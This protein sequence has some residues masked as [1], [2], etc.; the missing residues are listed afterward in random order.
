[1]TGH[2]L[3]LWTDRACAGGEMI[4]EVDLE[5]DVIEGQ[6]ELSIDYSGGFNLRVVESARWFPAAEIGRVLRVD[7]ASGLTSEWRINFIGDAGGIE[8]SKWIRCEPGALD[9]ARRCGFL[10]YR[11][12]GGLTRMAHG[13][14]QLA[15]H[16][17]IDTFL[18]PSLEHYGVTW[19]E[20]GVI[21]STKRID[22]TFE[23]WTPWQLMVALSDA[24]GLE[25][26]ERRIGDTG[27]ALDLV[28]QI[29]GNAEPV[30]LSTDK[31]LLR[32]VRTF[33]GGELATAVV[34]KGAAYGGDGERWGIEHA[35]WRVADKSGNTLTLEAHNGGPGP[36]A[37]RDQLVGRFVQR[38]DGTLTQVV[39]SDTNQ[40]VRVEDASG[41]NVGDDVVFVE[42]SAGSLMYELRNPTSAHGL[43]VATYTDNELRGERNHII[44][45]LFERWDPSSTDFQWCKVVGLGGDQYRYQLSGLRPGT[46][47]NVGDIV[48]YGIATPP[49]YSGARKV[50]AGGT[51]DGAGEVEITLNGGISV[52]SL[53]ASVIVVTGHTLPS[54]W[55]G[56]TTVFPRPRSG[57]SVPAVVD[58][59]HTFTDSDG[60]TG[61]L[62]LRGLPP[63]MPIYFGDGINGLSFYPPSRQTRGVAMSQAVVGPDGKV[64]LITSQ[65][66]EAPDGAPVTLVRPEIFAPGG[67]QM[68]YQWSSSPMVYPVRINHYPGMPTVWFT[69]AFSAYLLSDRVGSTLNIAEGDFRIEVWKGGPK[70]LYDKPLAAVWNPD[71]VSLGLGEV[72]DITLTASLDLTESMDLEF[73]VYPLRAN[74]TDYASILRYAA[75]TVKPEYN[76]GEIPFEGSLGTDI[77]QEANR[78]LVENAK[79]ARV[80]ECSVLDVAEMAGF[81]ARWNK[82]VPGGTL[83]IRDPDRDIY[84]VAR[85]VSMRPNLKNP[86]DTQITLDTRPDLETEIFQQQPS[87]YLTLDGSAHATTNRPPAKL[88]GAW[89]AV[90]SR[91]P[92][93]SVPPTPDVVPVKPY[94]GDG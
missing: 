45:P 25:W 18:L 24:T 14:V 59:N 88:R 90:G 74:M 69:A 80:Y 62:S 58:G 54:R 40:Q 76:E 68:V 78:R 79:P 51:V 60:W 22:L 30:Y 5:N 65:P 42:D 55:E 64:T 48:L 83:M 36:I 52:L 61:T 7:L 73:W 53:P 67:D 11:T 37:F 85:V 91:F 26:Q 41:I 21:E 89:R 16:Q 8:S 77:W 1:M 4:A 31:N 39:S 46:V 43:S 23:R 29:G 33:D 10:V 38:P 63:G 27:L 3:T 32:L 47:I 81:D 12:P 13:A 50:V 93:P 72:F 75:I 71:P 44:D 17:F 20:R 35:A 66:V 56:S 84:E 70:G 86:Q 19:Y 87:Q 49:N 6:P 9:L 82:L 92:I 2:R 34:M 28:E 15:P 94:E 57:M